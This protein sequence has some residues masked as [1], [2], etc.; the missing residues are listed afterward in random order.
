MT[1]KQGRAPNARRP[2]GT[3]RQYAY[4]VLRQGILTLEYAPGST[5]DEAMLVE[6]IGVSRTLVREAMISLA[7]EGLVELLPNRG[8]RVARFDLNDVRAY[9]EALE[10]HQ[11]AVTRWAAV[12]HR[13]EHLAAI[14]RERLAFEKAVKM[15]DAD[16]MIESNR[17]LHLAIAEGCG[18]SFVTAAYARLL[19]VGLRLS[20]LIVTYEIDP[21]QEVPLATHLERIVHQHREME[22]VITARDAD[23]AEKLGGSHAHLSLDRAVATLR[24]TLSGAITLPQ[25]S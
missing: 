10:L 9:H 22:Q 7:S 5:L 21:N 14:R 24:N 20:R 25:V 4:D 8:A 12:R 1:A 6:Q 19:T 2:K 13:P 11:R 17:S 15:R 16:A 18:N 23:A 3:G